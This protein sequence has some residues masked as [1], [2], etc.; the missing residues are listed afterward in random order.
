VSGWWYITGYLTDPEHPERL[1]S[2]QYMPKELV[3][4]DGCVFSKG[5]DLG[6]PGVKEERYQIRS[7]MDGQMNL[8]YFELLAE[9]I[10]PRN[11]RVGLC[12]VEL[13]PGVR[14][15]GKNIGYKKL[16]KRV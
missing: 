5:W 13:L 8:A 15:P 10:N 16:I 4:V 3:E 12:F 2:Y 7:I 11:E 9:I 6:L 1:Y 14:N